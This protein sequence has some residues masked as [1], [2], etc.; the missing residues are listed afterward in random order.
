MASKIRYAD[1]QNGESDDDTIVIHSENARQ[2]LPRVDVQEFNIEEDESGGEEEAVEEK[3]VIKKKPEVKKRKKKASSRANRIVLNLVNTK[4]PVIRECGEKMGYTMSRDDEEDWDLY[5]IDTSV[6]PER[7]MAMKPYQKINHFPGM[8]SVSRKNNLARNLGRML[9]AFPKEYKFFPPTWVLPGDYAEFRQQFNKK[10]AKT[11][12]VKPDAGCQGKGIFL[13]RHI[14]DIDPM[15]HLVCQRYLHKPFLVDG[16]KFDMR[17]YVLVSSCEPLRIFLYEEGL[18]RFATE[19]Y[20]APTGSNL[21]DVCMHLTNYAINKNNENFIFNTDASRNDVGHK[22]SLRSVYKLLQDRGHDM[23]KLMTEI[24]SIIIKAMV[25]VQPV[26]SHQYRSCQPDDLEM[27]MC[28]ELLGFDIMLDHKL[29]PWL[30]EINHSPSFTT[31]TPLDQQI[32]ENCIC[33]VMRLLNI[34]PSHR[35]RHKQQKKAEFQK[36][37]LT[38]KQTRKLDDRK[39]IMEQ[40]N[41]A[42]DVYEKEN[43]GGFK[44]IY[45]VENAAEYDK[46][47]DTAAQLWAEMTGSK[48]KHNEDDDKEAAAKKSIKEREKE[49][50]KSKDVGSVANSSNSNNSSADRNNKSILA[51]KS[52]QAESENPLSSATAKFTKSISALSSTNQTPSKKPPMINRNSPSSATFSSSPA[53]PV[54]ASPQTNQNPPATVSTGGPKPL[55]TVKSVSA[56]IVESRSVVDSPLSRPSRQTAGFSAPRLRSRTP[57][58]SELRSASESRPGSA[59]RSRAGTPSIPLPRTPTPHVTVDSNIQRGEVRSQSASIRQSDQHHSS[60]NQGDRYT[61]GQIGRPTL[62]D[63]A[64]Q[65]AY[66]GSVDCSL[67]KMYPPAGHDADSVDNVIRDHIYRTLTRSYEEADARLKRLESADR[68]SWGLRYPHV[69]EE[70]RNGFQKGTPRYSAHPPAPGTYVQTKLMEFS[71]RNG[72]SN[73]PPERPTVVKRPPLDLLK[74][75]S[76]S[77]TRRPPKYAPVKF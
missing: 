4:Y 66:I 9:K 70:D 69:I 31:D 76:I 29:R 20:I 21:S 46:Y 19:T 17:L 5:W 64:N 1:E 44:K 35:K 11:F 16:L 48:K 24:E 74:I 18:A 36:R 7:L 2:K 62:T 13:T 60:P 25:S 41:Q 8:Y 45:P 59:P 43:L 51:R 49:K 33:D 32:K 6:S 26:L 52:S 73:N 40:I 67:A 63:L 42:R 50:E 65:R 53:A 28:F 39:E 14:D 37:V 15:G 30:I 3:R 55:A 47:L 57:S 10:N 22:R 54:V 56:D 72:L 77:A 58:L 61:A 27:G 23:Q 34:N 68:N 75:S 71:P 38:G 12:I